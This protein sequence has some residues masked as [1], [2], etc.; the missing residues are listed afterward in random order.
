MSRAFAFWSGNKDSH[1]ALYR[2]TQA[3]VD[4]E[5][6]VGFIDTSTE[7]M[8]STRLPPE[9]IEEQAQLVGLPLLKLRVTRETYEREL[10]NMLFDLRTQGITLGIFPEIAATARRDFYRSLLSD[11]DMRPVFPLWGV[12]SSLLIE[13]E[14]KLMRSVIVRIDRMLSESYLGRDLTVEFIEYMQEN[15]YDIVGE[16]GEYDTFVCS[17]PLMDG[18]IFLTH[19]ERRATPEAIGLEIDYWKV[20]G[21]AKAAK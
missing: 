17:S 2:A 9:L 11:F 4:C 3:G 12:P 6:L 14:R 1:Y 7:L 19:A 15:G 8:M 20:E 21:G 10:R 5:L 16:S 18:E 13:R